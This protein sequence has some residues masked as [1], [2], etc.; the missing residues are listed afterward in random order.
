MWFMREDEVRV[1]KLVKRHRDHG[2][3]S[4]GL[5]TIIYICYPGISAITFYH[6]GISFAI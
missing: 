4:Y 6:A 1:M 2:G 5:T 3:T